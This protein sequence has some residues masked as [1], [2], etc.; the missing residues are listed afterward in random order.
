MWGR[1]RPGEMNIH[2]PVHVSKDEGRRPHGMPDP[3][4]RQGRCVMKRGKRT[5]ILGA[6]LATAC[7]ALWVA[8][9]RA[10]AGDKSRHRWQGI[11]IGVASTILL[12]HLMNPGPAAADYR[13]PVAP[14]PSYGYGPP[15]WDGPR[16]RERRRP[17]PPPGHWERV[18]IPD[19]YDSFGKFVEGHYES[20]WV[21]GPGYRAARAYRR[22]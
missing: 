17:C 8:V 2:G 14:R 20:Y 6:I 1:W 7:L 11:A 10:E 18:W 19:H 16:L 12:D 9:P 13:R 15:A 5:R 21:G 4:T 3:E 22:W